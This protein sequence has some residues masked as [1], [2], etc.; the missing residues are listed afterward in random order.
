MGVD[1]LPDFFTNPILHGGPAG[2]LPGGDGL[3]VQQPGL[4]QLF[5]QMVDRMPLG[6]V[7]TPGPHG[8]HDVA[9]QGVGIHRDA[10]DK[11]SGHADDL[12][13]HDQLLAGAGHAAG[14]VSHV[15]NQIQTRQGLAENGEGAL[16]TGLGIQALGVG[17]PG[18]APCGQAE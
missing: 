10:L 7:I 14:H 6:Q 13:A 16:D 8:I 2:C 12:V 11:S 3:P 1:D 18:Q 5:S 15:V 17:G 4:P 9:G